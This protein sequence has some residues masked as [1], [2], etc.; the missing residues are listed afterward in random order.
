MVCVCFYLL[1]YETLTY[2][3]QFIL[4]PFLISLVICHVTS[5]VRIGT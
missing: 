5:L 2:L 1:I 3:F 4:V